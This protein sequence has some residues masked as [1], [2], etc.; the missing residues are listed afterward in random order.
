LQEPSGISL[1]P[2]LIDPATRRVHP[3]LI[4]GTRGNDAI[5][6]D[7]WRYIRYSDGSEELYDHRVD[8][9][10]RTNLARNPAH[11]AQKAE[12]ARWLPR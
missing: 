5:R 12:L 4:A 2:Q 3:A 8:P 6:S 1:V 7:D 9:R 11:A 10:E